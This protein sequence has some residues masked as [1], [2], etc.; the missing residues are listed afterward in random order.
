MSKIRKVTRENPEGTWV[1]QRTG[2]A[3][4]SA[5]TTRY[6]PKASPRTRPRTV[7]KE[8]MI[9]DFGLA[10]YTGPIPPDAPLSPDNADSLG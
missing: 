3:E 9:T 8:V 5:R 4:K 2:K 6:T 7:P 10:V 1:N